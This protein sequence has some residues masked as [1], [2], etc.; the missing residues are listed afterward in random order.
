MNDLPMPGPLD[1]FLRHPPTPPAPDALREALLRKTAT[2]VRRR[3]R[4][5]VVAVAGAIAAVVMIAATI[6]W[7]RPPGDV[8]PPDAPPFVQ[9]QPAPVE[10]AQPPAV[11]LEW[12]AFDA[13]AE[14]KSTLYRQ[15][16]DRYVDD[17]DDLASAVRC[18]GQAVRTASTDSLRVE[19][20][21]NWLVAA[22]K[23][24]EIERRKE[25]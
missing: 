16:G 19:P 8:N 11:A 4:M 21:D 9:K 22:L 12:Q 5:R 6:V 24:D 25:K 20:G 23:A 10:S 13:A 3:R 7:L 1:D 15:A 17:A 2:L 14:H 18:Y